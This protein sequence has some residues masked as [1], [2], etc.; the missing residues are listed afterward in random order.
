M[1]Q[2]NILKKTELFVLDMDGTFYL[3]EDIIDGALDFLDAVK[4]CSKDY[5]FFTNNSSTSP[6]LYIEKLA[7]MNCHISREQIMTSGDV[8]I[9]FLKANYPEKKVYLLGTKPLEKNFEEAGINLFSPK[10]EATGY[11]NADTDDIPDIV[12]V[13]FDKTLTY[14]KLTNACTYIR[15]GAVFLATHL[16]INCPVKG[17]FIPDCGAICAAITL[18]TGKEPKYVGKPFKE[19]VDMIID[20]TGVDRDKIT[21]VGDRLYTD[22]ATGVKNGANGILVLSGEAT[23]RDI[24]KSEVKP[25]AVYPSIKEMGV[26]LDSFK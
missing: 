19:T 7:R 15:K 26:I 3:D 18:S 10:K 17:G 1:S 12:V 9:R 6:E 13:G 20:K 25:D 4:R 14:E 21:F 8:M 5:L 16:D 11:V 2:D 23:E 24:A 22:V